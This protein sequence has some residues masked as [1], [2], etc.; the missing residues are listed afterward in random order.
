MKRTE[1]KA[2]AARVSYDPETAEIVVSLTND[3][4]FRIPVREFPEAEKASDAVRG[5]VRLSANGRGIGWDALDCDYYWPYLMAILLGHDAWRRT[6]LSAFAGLQ[7]PAKA[8][9]SRANGAKGGRPR[10]R[11]PRASFR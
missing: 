8:R 3:S 1:R 11:Q 7:S 5:A 2:H 9:A 4:S 6:V 10:T